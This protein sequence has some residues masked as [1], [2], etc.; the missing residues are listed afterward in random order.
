MIYYAMSYSDNITTDNLFKLVG[1]PRLVDSFIHSKGVSEIDILN[2]VQEMGKGKLYRNNSCEPMAM[3]KLLQLFQEG[4]VV[5]EEQKA[6][7][8]KYM[9][10][11][12]SGPRRIK[13]LLPE[14]TTVA[15]KTGTGGTD[16][17]GVTEGINDI[18]IVTLPNGQKLALS[19]YVSDLDGELEAGEAIIA[20]IAKLVYDAAVQ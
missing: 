19:I 3:A 16:K 1:G 12:P 13:G 20:G 14:G 9:E 15:H 10:A 4:K 7:L 2:T 6:Y 11:A 18:G 5:G 8:L 17:K